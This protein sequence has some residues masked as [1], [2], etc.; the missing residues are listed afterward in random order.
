M[1]SRRTPIKTETRT[2]TSPS[3]LADLR[4]ILTPKTAILFVASFVTPLAAFML[5]PFLIIEFT[6]VMGFSPTEAGLLLAVR[7]L[8]AAALGFVGGWASDRFGL[9]RT[10]V[11]AGLVT[12]VVVVLM[13]VQ[14][15][16]PAL[17][18]LLAIL[19][20]SAS[21]VNACVR[22]LTQEAVP[23]AHRA[24]AQNAIHWLNNLGMA[25]AL[26]FSAYVL[27]AGTS[28]MPFFVTGAAYGAMAVLVRI[29]LRP[30]AV[31]SSDD[32]PALDGESG[33]SGREDKGS[34][35]NPLGI[36]SRD[37]A[38][39]L[40]LLSFVLWVTV[41]FQFESGVPLDMSY[42]F[43]GGA[44]LYGTLGVVDMAI[45]FCLQLWISHWLQKRSSQVWTF[46][47]FLLLGGL[48][49]GGISQTAVG[50]TVA[51][52]LLSLGEV[53]SLGQIMGLMSGLARPG[54]EG[55]YFSLFGMAQGLGA[56]LA[57]GFGGLAYQALHPVGLFG[58]CVPAALVSG[59]LYLAAHRAQ[60][61]AAFVQNDAVA[62]GSIG[63]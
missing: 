13:T 8:A 30:G 47:G 38:F 39:R 5:Y 19:G 55:G 21:T 57:Y 11:V 33:A 45:V 56:F 7:F 31:R 10:Y 41:E 49:F 46:V 12:A 53:L 50:W 3:F 29:A 63:A 28:R 6:H 15:T 34:S 22:G 37:R 23:E 24:I 59:L 16:V 36:L 43:V 32:A 54:Q 27:H 18:P 35:P 52:V 62:E 58:L 2:A 14:H 1:E 51:I 44:R 48:L 60:A 26:P 61:R 4:G 9:W 17:L 20:V 25:A 42:H 40:L